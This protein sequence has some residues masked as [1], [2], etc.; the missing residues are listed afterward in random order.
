MK[1]VSVAVQCNR[2]QIDPAD[3]L[4]QP[5]I[6]NT[7][8]VHCSACVS[9]GCATTDKVDADGFPNNL[10]AGGVG[11]PEDFFHDCANFTKEIEFIK[12]HN[13]KNLD[14]TNAYVTYISGCEREQVGA[15][16]I[17]TKGNRF[18]KQLKP[19]KDFKLGEVIWNSEDGTT[20][21]LDASGAEIKND[22][23]ISSP[24]SNVKNDPKNAASKNQDDAMKF[25]GIFAF[26]WILSSFM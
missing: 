6:V 22:N 2:F 20:H 7:K 18:Q 14:Y 17:A 15:L 5:T 16:C 8:F 19:I 1:I 11:C 12:S 25:I 4:K 24:D 10:I 9:Y 26:T 23:V 21:K 3:P 13:Q